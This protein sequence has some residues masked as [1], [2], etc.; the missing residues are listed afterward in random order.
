[1]PKEKINSF[2]KQQLKE[3]QQQQQQ[4]TPEQRVITKSKTKN[5]N[6]KDKKN[7]TSSISSNKTI[8]KSHNKS[9]SAPN[10]I[11]LEPIP[12][13]KL[14]DEITLNEINQSLTSLAALID[15]TNHPA[16]TTPPTIRNVNRSNAKFHQL[17][18]SVPINE[19]VVD[20]YSCAYVKSLNLLHG[21]MF[22]TRNFICFYSKI[23]TSENIIIL[24]LKHINSITKTMHALIF[25]TAIRI[26][27]KNSTYSFT[28]FRSRSHTLDHLTSLLNESRQVI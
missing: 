24:K 23:L 3:G 2:K 18:P 9:L 1:M 14:K 27:T 5:E 20:T 15:M 8:K 28:S 26:E 10:F 12:S 7:K 17:F 4:E 21:V 13:N 19:T 11:K 25:P 6:K 16:T 22:L